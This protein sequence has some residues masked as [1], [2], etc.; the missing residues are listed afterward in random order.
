MSKDRRSQSPPTTQARGHIPR[1]GRDRRAVVTSTVQ[2]V[3]QVVP[4]QR[5]GVESH[6]ASA[7]HLPPAGGTRGRAGAKKEGGNPNTRG[8]QLE[9]EK[10]PAHLLR[11]HT[12]RDPHVPSRSCTITHRERRRFRIFRICTTHR[13]PSPSSH[14]GW[15]VEFTGLE[16]AAVPFFRSGVV[17][18]DF[19][20]KHVT[21]DTLVPSYHAQACTRRERERE[22]GF[23]TLCSPQLSSHRFKSHAPGCCLGECGGSFTL[24]PRSDQIVSDHI[25]SGIRLEQA[26]VPFL[27]SGVVGPDFISKHM[28]AD[29]LAPS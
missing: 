25:V 22:E 26:A 6:P 23:P 5:G 16:Q 12:T 8:T 24:L 9:Q 13:S 15:R 27:R 4:G 2:E 7:A 17:G 1:G 19:I 29:T 28:T 10:P 18:P 3:S 14:R 21:T 20:R 11:K